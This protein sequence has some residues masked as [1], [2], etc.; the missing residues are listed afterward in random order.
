MPKEDRKS[1]KKNRQY[2]YLR[3]SDI[4]YT[5]YL[6]LYICHIKLIIK[7]YTYIKN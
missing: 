7:R 6:I 3:S 5:P 4:K 1:N 2:K